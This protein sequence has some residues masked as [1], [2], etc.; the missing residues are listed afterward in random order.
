MAI[1]E[2]FRNESGLKYMSNLRLITL[3]APYDSF[4]AVSQQKPSA[5]KISSS[6]ASKLPA[7]IVTKLPVAPVVSKLPIAVTAVPSIL[8]KPTVPTW[9]EKAVAPPIIPQLP[10]TVQEKIKTTLPI[11]TPVV[12]KAQ[13]LI[14][15]APE[16]LPKVQQI[17]T[18]IIQNKPDQIKE[19]IALPAIKDTL[20][21][22]KSSTTSQTTSAPNVSKPNIIEKANTILKNTPAMIS[23]G[24]KLTQAMLQKKTND[25]KKL[26]QNIPVK[27]AITETKK[28]TAATET[29]K[30]IPPAPAE[31]PVQQPTQQPIQ[32]SI[33]PDYTTLNPYAVNPYASH[34]QPIIAQSPIEQKNEVP[35]VASQAETD[36][37][38]LYW[39]AGGLGFLGL[40]LLLRK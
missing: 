20:D 23:W 10:I 37:S 3:N 9:N 29:V 19:L 11:S 25:V 7:A 34:T 36:N 30:P 12:L 40:I 28:E 14:Q 31:L 32:Q 27:E 39:V 16:I 5:I 22:I 17:A 35:V 21:V 33:V 18:A 13:E 2:Y 1:T 26:V 38:K 24:Q 15:K 6:V 8:P 4:G